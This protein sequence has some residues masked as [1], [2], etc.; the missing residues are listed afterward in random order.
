MKIDYYKQLETDRLILRKV[1]HSDASDIFEY[2]S[3]IENTKFMLWNTH[4]SIK[5]TYDFIDFILSKYED[6]TTLDYV[7]ELKETGKVIG[8]G[9]L[10]DLYEMPHNAE[11]GYII[12]KKYWGQGLVA[13]AM[14][15]IIDHLFKSFNVH[16]IQ[17]KHFEENP[18]SGKVMQ[19]LGMIYEGKCV[20]KLFCRGKY[21]TTKNYYLL[22]PNN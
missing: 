17:A 6:M 15:A 18:N 4:T 12:N 1:R 7:F 20:E 3:D 2:A 13:E 5:D 21:W 8:T 11:I 22:N 14:Q 19:K 10:F 16:R 9:G